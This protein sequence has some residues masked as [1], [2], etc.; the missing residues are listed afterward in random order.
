VS[1]RVTAISGRGAYAGVPGNVT[2]EVE[3]DGVGLDAPSGRKSGTWNVAAR[4]RQHGGTSSL[5]SSPSGRGTLLTWSAPL[6]LA[7]A[8]T[9]V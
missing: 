9:L 7:A 6:K 8:S 5:E 3:D 2:I 1:V 4:A